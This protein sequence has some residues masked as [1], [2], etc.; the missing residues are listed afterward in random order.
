MTLFVAKIHN[1]ILGACTEVSSYEEGIDLLRGMAEEQ[2][3]RELTPEEIDG[4]V[5]EYEVYN[6][7]DADNVY[8]WS[9]GTFG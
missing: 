5:N 9:I 3:D 7:E 6:D 4:L 1:N 8:T 2:L